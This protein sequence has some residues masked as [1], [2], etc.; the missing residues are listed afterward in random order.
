MPKIVYFV[1]V[2]MQ[3]RIFKKSH[4]NQRKPAKTSTGMESVRNR[5]SGSQMV[6]GMLKKN[7]FKSL[8]Y[9][10]MTKEVPDKSLSKF[11]KLVPQ[12]SKIDKNNPW[13]IYWSI[14]KI[15]PPINSKC[16]R[17]ALRR[18]L[19]EISDWSFEFSENTLY[20]LNPLNHFTFNPKPIL[21]ITQIQ[22]LIGPKTLQA[23]NFKQPVHHP[24]YP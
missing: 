18:M 12:L 4:K 8:K 16:T 21:L 22:N 3:V 17:M 10:R 7:K 1:I 2:I 11:A 14:Y 19:G 15:G 24:I 13:C 20:T 6:K 9:P 5:S 23:Q